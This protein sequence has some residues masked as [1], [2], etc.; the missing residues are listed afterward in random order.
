MKENEK[1]LDLSGVP[2]RLKLHSGLGNYLYLRDCYD[3]FIEDIIATLPRRRC[4]TI[5]I[6]GTAGIGKSALFLVLLKLLFD[7]PSR[8]GLATRSFYYQ[9][10]DEVIWLYRHLHANDFSV[11]SVKSWQLDETFPLFADMETEQGSPK[12]HIGISLIFTSL[13]PSRYK[14]LTKNGWQK[15]LPTWSFEEQYDYFSSH[16]FESEYGKEVAQRAYENIQFF[17]GSIRSNI[18]ASIAGQSPA[19]RIEEAIETKGE[20]LCERYFNVFSGSVH[21]SSELLVHRNPKM[22]GDRYDFDSELVVFSFA[23]PFVVRR[24]LQLKNNILATEARNKYNAGTFRRGD[25]GHEFE[26]LCLHG[27]Q[28]SNVEF[29]AQPL[30][31]GAEATTVIFPDK[32]VLALH[33]R[34][35]ENYLQVDVLYIPPYGNLESGNAFCLMKINDRWTLVILQCTIAETHSVKQNGIKI[36]HD[37]YTKNSQLKVDD[38]VIM[39]MIPSNGKLKT[40]QSLVMQKNRDVQRAAIAVTALSS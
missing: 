1:F 2:V 29:L 3:D 14:E 39:F 35:Q 38:T 31:D 7:D 19:E 15:M 25:N 21:F 18:E 32:E 10:S 24:L 12:E 4:K 5:A 27:F 9:T 16:Q 26:L 34:D 11:H 20:L 17:G 28:I 22:V 30:T 6:L 40:E 33:W 23:S 37:C 36:I 8:F 13:R